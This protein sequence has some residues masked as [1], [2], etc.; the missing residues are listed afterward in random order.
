[1]K[2]KK[3]KINDIG[4][5]LSK[6]LLFFA[7]A[8]ASLRFN[9]NGMTSFFRIL[10][11]I[12]IILIILL[13]FSKAIKP[14]II[15]A[16]IIIYNII[17]SKIYY[18]NIEFDYYIFFTYIFI[19]FMIVYHYSIKSDNFSEEFY[20][21]LDF[22]TKLVLLLSIIQFF[23]RIPYPFV[24]LPKRIG[25]NIFMSNENELSSPLG[26]MLIIYTYRMI[27]YKEKKQLIKILLILLLIFIN[28]AKLTIFG[29]VFGVA[30][31]LLLAKEV[32]SIDKKTK[33]K[34]FSYGVKFI[35]FATIILFLIFIVY[36]LNPN[37]KFR[38]YSISI[39]ELLFDPIISILKLER[40]SYSGGSI[41]D[42]S[43]AIVFGL[44]ELIKTKFIGIGLGNSVYMLS[45]PQYK[46]LTAKSMHNF[47]FQMV[48][49]MGVVFISLLIYM[50]LEQIKMYKQLEK[51]NINALK[52]SIS[53]AF[54]FLSSQSSIGIFSNYYFWIII[55][56]II[57]VR[58]KK[59]EVNNE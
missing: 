35:L 55:V 15:F 59:V 38:D 56:Y 4:L 23:I 27:F 18:N 9:S 43:S 39:K 16:M 41:Y 5:F 31:I 40:L 28:D 14:I 26:L 54:V 47:I 29:V 8:N 12:F 57:F 58:D 3:I 46:L 20:Y 37:L 48:T 50:I 51:K 42:R 53:M 2:Q 49:E 30:I 10:S 34:R 22:I 21:Y 11:P 52:I 33:S 1:M 24:N 36:T 6:I 25:V 44:T 7:I 32:K 13:N 45:M 19:T 17:V